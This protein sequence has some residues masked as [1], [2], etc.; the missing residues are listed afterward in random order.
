MPRV[1]MCGEVTPLPVVPR[2]PDVPE[3]LE[4]FEVHLWYFVASELQALH[5]HVPC[6]SRG[7]GL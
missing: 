4:T 2:K 3:G 5:V 7:V 1:Q 6:G